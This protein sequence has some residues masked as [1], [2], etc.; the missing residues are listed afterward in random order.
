MSDQ[1]IR[2]WGLVVS[3]G[4]EGIDLSQMRIEFNVTAADATMPN[5]LQARIYNLAPNT[6]QR[7][8]QEFQ[9][10]TLQAGFEG[11][12]FAVIFE[13]SIKQVKRG[14]MSPVDTYVEIYAAD[15][16]EAHN[17]AVVNKSLAKG[18]KLEEQIKAINESMQPYGT[19]ANVQIPNELGTG[20]T[21][22]RGKALF[23]LARERMNDVAAT[24]NCSWS[25]QNGQVTLIEETGYLPG[26]IVRI[27][28]RTGMIGIPETTDSGV[29]VTVL[30]NPLIK[31]GTRIE[32]DNAS[33][34]QL[35]VR[36]QGFPRYGDKSFPANVSADGVYRVLVIEHQGDNR[37]QPW[38]SKITCLAVDPS[39]SP[40]QSVLPDG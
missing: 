16:D 11:G 27:N 7:I 13:G 4:E 17:W 14:R 29:E 39:S 1:Y 22:I 34:N 36:E 30:L 2:K 28:S 9:H 40:G 33:I 21:L 23:G 31:I 32:L 26:E 18:A 35:Q 25:I 38:Y 19:T 3:A 8:Q 12:N 6:A 5:V 20:G 24:G 37:G 15:G 10:V